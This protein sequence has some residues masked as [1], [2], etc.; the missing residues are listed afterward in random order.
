MTAKEKAV[1]VALRQ[2]LTTEEGKN[3][4]AMLRELR[5]GLIELHKEPSFERQA[6]QAA[7]AGGWEACVAVL[8]RIAFKMDADATITALTDFIND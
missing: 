2:F 3:L 1:A 7:R 5:P 4:L 8:E 6:L